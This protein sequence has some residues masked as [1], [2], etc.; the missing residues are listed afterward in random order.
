MKGNLNL[1]KY[2]RIQDYPDH[3]SGTA[4]LARILDGLGFR[5]YWATQGLRAEDYAFRLA[6]DVMNIEEFAM[7]VWQLM[8]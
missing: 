7:H 6:G 5:F 1:E 8:N 4:V 3:V 2:Y